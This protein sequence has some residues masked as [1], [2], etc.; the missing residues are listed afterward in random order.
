MS[1]LQ[2]VIKYTGS[3]SADIVSRVSTENGPGI[4]DVLYVELGPLIAVERFA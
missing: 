3:N 2:G 4:T 1:L